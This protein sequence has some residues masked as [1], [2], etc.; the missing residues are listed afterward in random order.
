MI[1]ISLSFLT[2]TTLPRLTPQ[3]A[4]TCNGLLTRE[5]CLASLKQF[6]KGK[7]PSMDGLTAEFY[8][9]FWEL[10][11]QDLVDSL[12]HAFEVGEMS[13]LQKR[14]VITLIP[15]KN[16]NKAFLDNWRPISLPNTDYK[17]ATKA[18]ASRISKV[19]PVLIN[20]DQT[21]FIK[22]RS[23]A[24]SVHLIADIIE[25]TEALNTPGIALFLDFKKAFDSIEWNFIFKTLAT[26][27]FELPLLQRVRTF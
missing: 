15:K 6:S 4:D 7:S 20:G 19:L 24:Q 10:L 5:E 1:S 22:G 17:I 21:S 11:G 18:I 2:R 25:Y 26:L 12:N 16:K 27:G 3:E 9:F 14:G 8:L 23:I 13:I